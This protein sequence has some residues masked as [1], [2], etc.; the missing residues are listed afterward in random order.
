MHDFCDGGEVNA[1]FG[2]KEKIHEYFENFL[3][4]KYY[5]HD[6]EK[7]SFEDFF[8]MSEDF[9]T[10]KG[11]PVL[12]RDI[13]Y[14]LVGYMCSLGELEETSNFYKRLIQDNQHYI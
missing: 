10:Y 2:K 9:L 5:E 13:V 4:E 6:Q 8:L 1:N 12:F 14:N 11:T 7:L 3:K